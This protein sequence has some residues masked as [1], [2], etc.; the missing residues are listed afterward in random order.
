MVSTE[1]PTIEGRFAYDPEGGMF[2]ATAPT[3]ARCTSWK[4]C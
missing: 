1:A 3:E 2:C 4:R